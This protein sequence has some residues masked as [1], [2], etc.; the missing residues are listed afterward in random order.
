MNHSEPFI[1]KTKKREKNSKN[2]ESIESTFW[3][4]LAFMLL[5]V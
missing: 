3:R 1:T 2:R 5:K 4:N